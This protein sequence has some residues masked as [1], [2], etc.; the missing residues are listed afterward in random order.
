MAFSVL[1]YIGADGPGRGRWE[2][3]ALFVNSTK[4][5][6]APEGTTTLVS[7]NCF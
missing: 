5:V 3:F 4:K 7:E 6:A 1:I 2:R